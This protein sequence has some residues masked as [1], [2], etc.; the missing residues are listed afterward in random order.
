M[1]LLKHVLRYISGTLDLGLKFDREADMLDD[2]VEYTIFNFAGS[3]TDRKSTRGYVFI[4]VEVAINHCS[5]TLSIVT[6]SIY[7]LRYVAICE[8]R[9]K[10]VWLRRLLAQLRF[11]KISTP[12]RLYTDNQGSIAISNN[13]KFHR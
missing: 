8:S 13:P 2:V 11:R 3:K 6:L 1:K 12:V 7:E 5:K 4:I 10:A 9:K